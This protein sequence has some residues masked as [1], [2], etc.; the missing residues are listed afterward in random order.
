MQATLTYL[1]LSAADNEQTPPANDSHWRN[2]LVRSSLLLPN[3]EL[4]CHV[5]YVGSFSK[6]VMLQPPMS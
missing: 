4:G 2:V 6:A 1:S 5:S 3:V